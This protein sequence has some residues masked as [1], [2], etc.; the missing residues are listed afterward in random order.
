M[1]ISGVTVLITGQHSADRA[2][3]IQA[4]YRELK[5]RGRKVEVLD[6]EAVTALLAR[7]AEHAADTKGSGN[8]NNGIVG[9]HHPVGNDV[10]L[11]ALDGPPAKLSDVRRTLG[12]VVQVEVLEMGRSVADIEPASADASGAAAHSSE[13]VLQLHAGSLEQS[14]TRVLLRLEESAIFVPAASQPEAYDSEDE[15]IIRR[16]L[17]SLGYL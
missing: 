12:R 6:D 15:E 17:E 16:R 5:L 3:L 7:R 13:G 14:V 9:E 2:T 11:V 10:S 4:L 8:S 1:A